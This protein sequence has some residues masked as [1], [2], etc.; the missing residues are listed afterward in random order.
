MTTQYMSTVDEEEEEEYSFT[1]LR[2]AVIFARGKLR[3]KTY[4][5]LCIRNDN[6]RKKSLFC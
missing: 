3:R 5:G 1:R 4:T 6:I 2:Y